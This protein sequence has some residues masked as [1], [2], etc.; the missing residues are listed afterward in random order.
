MTCGELL[1]LGFVLQAQANLFEGQ[2]G[3]FRNAIFYHVLSF[4][5]FSLAVFVAVVSVGK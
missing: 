2:E 3:G 1:I 5:V 4:V